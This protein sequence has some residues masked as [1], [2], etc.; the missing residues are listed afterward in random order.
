LYK[1]WLWQSSCA[2]EVWS[3]CG[4]EKAGRSASASEE[5]VEL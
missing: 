5:V 4:A 3:N 2:A 1:F